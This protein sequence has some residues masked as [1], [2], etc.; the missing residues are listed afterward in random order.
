[1]E[2]M[3]L[4]TLNRAFRSRAIRP[5]SV[6]RFEADGNRFVLVVVR[7][8]AGDSS[9]NCS[10]REIRL[11]S[12]PIR[13]TSSQWPTRMVSPWPNSFRRTGMPFTKV[14]LWL[15]RSTK[16]KAASVSL[17]EKCFRDTARSCRHKWLL[18]SRPT[19]NWLAVSR[20]TVPFAD[21]DTTTTLE[22]TDCLR[23]ARLAQS[24]RIHGMKI[25]WPANTMDSRA[26]PL[27]H[28]TAES[29][30]GKEVKLAGNGLSAP[31]EAPFRCNEV[32]VAAR[33]K[34]PGEGSPDF[35]V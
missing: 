19:K 21:P 15:S 9:R 26:Y 32:V 10:I 2:L 7:K 31:P 35:F 30:L 6:P 23:A 27:R 22:S 17:M 34:N 16:W 13:N 4:A 3:V 8:S 11:S 20:T 1:M 25:A 33:T 24:W 14:P 12:S 29:K 5:T 18:E 28:R